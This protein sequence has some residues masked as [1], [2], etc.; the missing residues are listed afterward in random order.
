LSGRTPA[1]LPA[2][3]WSTRRGARWPPG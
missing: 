2:C 1:R 3:S